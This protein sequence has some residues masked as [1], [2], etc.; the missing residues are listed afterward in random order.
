MGKNIGETKKQTKDKESIKKEVVLSEKTEISIPKDTVV[1]KEIPVHEEQIVPEKKKTPEFTVTIK[2]DPQIYHQQLKNNDIERTYE[3]VFS[4]IDKTD[5]KID[6]DK[7]THRNALSAEEKNIVKTLYTQL[8]ATN[9]ENEIKAIINKINDIKILRGTRDICVKSIYILKNKKK[10]I[11]YLQGISQQTVR[12]EY[13][14]INQKILE[15]QNIIQQY[16]IE[17]KTFSL[18]PMAG[19]ENAS[20]LDDKK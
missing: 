19:R 14:I 10:D 12:R 4:L 20:D 2:K 3:E 8:V 5:P 16:V 7:Y 17:P 6:Q 15:A 18:V 1:I 13:Q 11:S 9:N